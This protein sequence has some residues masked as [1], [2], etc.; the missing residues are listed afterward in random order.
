MRHIDWSHRWI[1]RG[2]LTVPP[3]S[4]YVY[5][6]IIGTVYPIKK[7]VVEAFNKK[8]NRAGLD[9]TGK[10]GNYRNVNKALNLDVFYVMSGSHLF[11]WNL[12]VALMTLGYI[13]Y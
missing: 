7:T 2:S 5:W 11:G 8:L 12:A 4:H 1:Y 10:N 9:T 3:C 6:N 13:Y